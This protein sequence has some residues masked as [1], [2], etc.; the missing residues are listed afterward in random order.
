MGTRGWF[1]VLHRGIYYRFFN[2]HDSYF[3]GLGT[4]LINKVIDGGDSVLDAIRMLLDLAIV[5]ERCSLI[6]PTDAKLQTQWE[7][8]A[9]TASSF[10]WLFENE[11]GQLQ[12]H[13]E[14]YLHGD[15][16]YIEF[17]YVVDLDS[18]RFLASH[19]IRTSLI[20]SYPIDANLD[21]TFLELAKDMKVPVTASGIQSYPIPKVELDKMLSSFEQEGYRMEGTEPVSL[22]K[23]AWVFEC[24]STKSGEKVF[25]KV[26]SVA[27]R[28]DFSF[29]N[30][31]R[32]MELGEYKRPMAVAA[33][34]LACSSGH[35]NVVRII[36]K[37]EIG[38]ASYGT[39]PTL[40]L[41]AYDGD[42]DSVLGNLQRHLAPRNYVQLLCNAL[43]DV[44]QGIIFLHS[45][46]IVHHDIKAEN[47][48]VRVGAND[49]SIH[50]VI[51]DFESAGVPFPAE[52]PDQ[53][54]GPFASN[55]Y[56]RDG[57]W[58]KDWKPFKWTADYAHP[59]RET[60]NPWY[61]DSYSLACVI[62][63]LLGKINVSKE[64]VGILRSEPETKEMVI[65][66]LEQVAK[67]LRSY[68]AFESQ[69]NPRDAKENTSNVPESNEQR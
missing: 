23:H 66:N 33:M 13:K 32:K 58:V 37:T 31:G 22:G 48:L 39:Y 49:T 14:P 20:F 61:L 11:Q 41:E 25:M 19:A 42:L 16:L 63:E 34:L 1:V 62:E 27:W 8:A 56:S 54:W 36:K 18:K 26:F 9:S 29:G 6:R 57:H 65:E 55:G 68:G 59:N 15:G 64:L 67:I 60:T 12:C 43:A 69:T 2:S 3:E 40:V 47:V 44:A 50:A 10:H 28:P 52:T 5:D 17:I 45:K 51:C 53:T 24:S 46:G 4:D 30:Q 21:P 38:T 7:N 35:P